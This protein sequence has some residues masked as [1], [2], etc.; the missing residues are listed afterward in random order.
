MTTGSNLTLAW[1]ASQVGP[2]PHDKIARYELTARRADTGAVL[3]TWDAGTAT[4]FVVPDEDVPVVPF[5]TTVVGV[6]LS[7]LVSAPSNA[8]R[9]TPPLAPADLRATVT[10][11]LTTPVGAP[12]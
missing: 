1:T 6:A 8:L 12:V 2:E 4:T 10:V 11:L 9:L 5:I 7:G 3:A